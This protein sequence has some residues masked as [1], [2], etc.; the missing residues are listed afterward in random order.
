MTSWQPADLRQGLDGCRHDPSCLATD[1]HPEAWCFV[2]IGNYAVD[3]LERHCSNDHLIPGTE[4]DK[5]LAWAKAFNKNLDPP[6]LP[7][8]SI[9]LYM[10]TFPGR[11]MRLLVELLSTA[12]TQKE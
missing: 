4:T 10:N 8:Q 11:S 2:C 9:Q 6:L 7:E 5:F 3:E 12:L 1:K